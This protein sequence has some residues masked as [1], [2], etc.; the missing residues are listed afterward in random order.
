MNFAKKNFNKDHRTYLKW[1]APTRSSIW[2]RRFLFIWCCQWQLYLASNLSSG[3]SQSQVTNCFCFYSE[4]H[5]IKSASSIF[6]SMGQML[7][8]MASILGI[9]HGCIVWR[10]KNA[11]KINAPFEIINYGQFGIFFYPDNCFCVAFGTKRNKWWAMI[12]KYLAMNKSTCELL[13]WFIFDQ[14]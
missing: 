6:S 4:F 3:W 9:L 10:E 8:K 7:S 13:F 14:Q 2:W 12:Y 5:R 1:W 11:V